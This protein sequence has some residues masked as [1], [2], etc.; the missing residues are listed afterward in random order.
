MQVRFWGVRG[1]IPVAGSHTL[2]TGGNTSC[3]EVVHD[4]HRL[5]IDGG[6]GLR[7]LGDS[8]GFQPVELTVLFTHTHWDHIQG[9]PFFTPAYHAG[10]RLTFAGP[11]RDGCTLR[12]ALATQMRPPTFP[13]H[14]DELAARIQYSPLDE[15]QVLEV[16]PFRVSSVDLMHPQ[17]VRAYRVEAGGRVFVHATDVEHG[18]T[19]DP[20][21]IRFAEGAD[22]LAHDAQY[23]REEYIGVGGP[24]RRGWGHA[25]WRDAVE[26]ASSAG[27]RRLALFH[28]D[29]RRNDEGVDA[30]EA[31][32]REVLPSCFAAR[33]DGPI[34]L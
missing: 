32:A 7:E 18:D 3:I 26:V 25:T 1:S 34:A 11:T 13:I 16:G 27:V 20:R 12:D 9:V 8:I 2:R 23:T 28:H 5:V 33:E 29:P 24:S 19:L 21:L 30:I 17:G 4:G 15:D 6:T 14:L 22:L 10:S 31:A